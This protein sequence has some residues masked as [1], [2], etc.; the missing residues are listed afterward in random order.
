MFVI[1]LTVSTFFDSCTF[2]SWKFIASRYIFKIYFYLLLGVVLGGEGLK[3]QG[4]MW[5]DN[6]NIG[7][8]FLQTKQPPVETAV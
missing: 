1:A 4:L 7:S 5:P 2:G 8:N 3:D 6:R